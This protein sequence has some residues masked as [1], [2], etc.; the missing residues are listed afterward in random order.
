MILLDHNIPEHQVELLR[1]TRLRPQQI[2]REV[3]RPEW[4]DFEEI[5]RH[6]HRLKATTFVT[7]DEDFF[8]RRL[9]HLNYSLVVV[10]GLV[11]DTA[12]D[13]Q[14]FLRH[15]DFRIKQ[16]RMGKVVL[17]SSTSIAWWEIGKESQQRLSWEFLSPPSH[18]R[19]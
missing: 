11:I 3:G 14:R 7:R 18:R 12:K 6:L 16:Q 5:L 17:L 1:R 15:R 8:H 2:G 13:V 4:Q 19:G 10:S 9:C